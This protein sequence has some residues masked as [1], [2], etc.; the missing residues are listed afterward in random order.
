MFERQRVSALFREAMDA[1][2]QLITSEF[3]IQPGP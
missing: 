3:G 2:A 1:E